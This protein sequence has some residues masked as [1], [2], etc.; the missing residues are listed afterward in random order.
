[1]NVG[2]FTLVVVVVVVAATAVAVVLSMN[3]V[4]GVFRDRKECIALL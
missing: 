1:M 2:F 4:D 3:M